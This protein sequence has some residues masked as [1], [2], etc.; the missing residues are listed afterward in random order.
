MTDVEAGI[1]WPKKTREIYKHVIDSTRWND[2]VFRDDDIVIS[3]WAKSGTTLT[4]QICA[5]LV[6]NGADVYGPNFSPW[7]DLMVSDGEIPRAV[8]QTHRRFLKTHLPIDS[9]VYSPCAK[10][11]FVG[12]DGRDT[13]WSWYNHWA[14]YTPE[15]LANASA[16]H[17]DEPPIGYPNPDIRLAFL[18][19]LDTD[20]Y[21]TVPFF[22][23]MQGWFDARHL[24]NLLM[25]HFNDLRSDLP[26]QIRRIAA[27][28][29]IDIDPARFDDIVTHC[30]PRLHARQGQPG[31][32]VHEGR[33][34]GRRQHLLPQR[35]QRSLEGYSNARRQRS[36]SARGRTTPVSRMRPLARDGPPARLS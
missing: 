28:L 4:Q 36:L 27:F 6:F 35:H 1:A 30:G 19:W 3:T 5:Q 7:I 13:F 24:P 22:S 20:A 31:C 16:R 34:Q 26:G 12:R 2:F 14:N 11:I 29:E 9:I 8:A 25:L 33:L 10:Y 15:D 23:H 18:E 21:P 32:R 17:P